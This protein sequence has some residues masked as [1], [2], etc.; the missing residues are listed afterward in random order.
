MLGT[1][2]REIE[3]S[4]SSA[5]RGRVPWGLTYAYLLQ[6]LSWDTKM[7]SSLITSMAIHSIIAA[8]IFVTLQSRRTIETLSSGKARQVYEAFA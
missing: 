3:A 1:R 6:R 4:V 2:N 7:A 5:K 8:Q